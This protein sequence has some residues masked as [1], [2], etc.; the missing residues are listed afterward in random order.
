[1]SEFI[2]RPSPPPHPPSQHG[3][4]DGRQEI[5]SARPSRPQP[6]AP[7][8]RYHKPFP[9]R[10]GA[11]ARS[12][13]EVVGGRNTRYC[14]GG[15]IIEQRPIVH[16][17][18]D[19]SGKSTSTW[20]SVSPC[21]TAKAGYAHAKRSSSGCGRFC[22]SYDIVPTAAFPSS[23]CRVFKRQADDGGNPGCGLAAYPTPTVI[24]KSR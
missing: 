20:S 23:F 14:H 4:V 17:F 24:E 18:G 21:G 22:Y 19:L 9:L 6:L 1:M 13:V 15:R 3:G 5:C 11:C 10:P 12:R 2:S 7:P 8:S 16:S